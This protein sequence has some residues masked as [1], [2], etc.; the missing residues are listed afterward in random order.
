MFQKCSLLDIQNKLAKMQQSQPIKKE[1][2][3]LK[4][5]LLWFV[6]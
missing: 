6:Y 2:L 4:G 3:M 1:P 5:A